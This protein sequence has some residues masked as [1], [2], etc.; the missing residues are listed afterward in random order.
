MS[1]R[2]PIIRVAGLDVDVVRKEIKN[3]HIG[4]Y[5]PFGGVR[6]A[7]PAALDDEA[8]RLAVVSR[9]DWLRR[10][11]K[12]IRS[13]VRQSRR[14]MVDGETHHV[15]GRRYRLRVIED[16]AR[17]KV[18]FAGSDWLELHVA[19]GA[20]RDARERRLMA[21]YREQIK[22]EI[23][24]IV[25]KWAS[26][27]E[28]PEPEWGVK[29]MKTKWGTCNVDRQRIWLNL[30]LAKKP[31]ECLEYVIVHEMLHLCERNHTDRFYALQDRYLPSWRH[32]RDV[33]NGEPL[34]D[35]RWEPRN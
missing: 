24:S 17:R 2:S 10:K 7:A 12:Q 25:E 18:G 3:L 9:L 31:P 13:Q 29:R 33:L 27:L 20:D 15:W 28:V 35:E 6:V 19:K 16:G 1:T 21:W 4:V 34:A 14:E 30:E 11:Q 22:A 5:P 32:R 8:V 26:A 23:P